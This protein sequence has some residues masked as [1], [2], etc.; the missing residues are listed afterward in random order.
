M[1][2]IR[3]ATLITPTEVIPNG[4]LLIDG[5]K[6]LALGPD[7]T[8]SIPAGASVL[9][10]DGQILAPGL[11]ELQINGGF[12]QD[13]TEKPESLWQVAASLPRYGVTSFLPT[14]ITS[15]LSTVK[16]AL[17]I[18]KSGP[19]VGFQGAQPLGYHLEGPMLNPGKKGAHNPAY[20]LPPSLE[21]I[22]GWSPENGVRLVTLAPEIPGALDV[23]QELRRRGVVVSAGHSLASFD[24]ALRA[25]DAGVTKGTHLFNAQPPL[26]HRQPG[27]A[28][29]LLTD[30][31]V[32]VGLIADGIHVHPAVIDLAW[33][34]KGPRGLV[35]VT[36]AMAALGMPP[37]TYHLGD[38]DVIVDAASA[39]LANGTLAGSILTQDAAVRNLVRYTGCSL[40]EALAAASLNPANLLGFETKGRLEPGADA[41]LVLLNAEGYIQSTWIAGK[42]VFQKE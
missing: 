20:I 1:Q 16:K 29:A 23:I 39:R 34:M 41:D 19:P 28:A 12:G 37:G 8:I 5:G 24:E 36:D 2:Y 32:T 18:W 13:F 15:P 4:T 31:R 30:R 22:E 33:R 27:L 21:V 3:K 7:H 26:D 11:V 6:I 14:V 35:L 42:V 25:F 40:A 17:D 10:A 9:I 38:Y